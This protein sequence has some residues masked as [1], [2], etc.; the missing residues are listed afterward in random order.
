MSLT[1]PS[2]LT[3]PRGHDVVAEW[4]RR[5]I[6]RG[7]LASTF[8]FV[9]PEGIGKRTFA[10]WLAQSLLCRNSPD[11]AVQP[12]G[13]CPSCQQV[14]AGTHPDLELVAKPVDKSFIP[15]DLLIGDREHRMREG[16]CHNI[17]L[18]PFCG[19]RK[20]AIIDDA[21]FLN[22]EGANCLLKTLEEPPPNSLIILIGTSEQKQLP[23]IRSRCQIVRFNALSSELV[24]ELLLANGDTQSRDEA[25][26]WAAQ[27]EG[28][29]ARAVEVADQDLG[30]FREQLLGQLSVPGGNLL[31]FAREV[32]AFVDRAGK[33]AVARRNRLRRV[34]RIAAGFFHALMHALSGV[35]IDADVQLTS[36][37]QRR[38]ATWRGDAETAVACLERCFDAEA[39]ID[40]N[41]SLAIVV[42]C[43]LDDIGRLMRC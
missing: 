43:W 26:Q 21:D 42:E 11:D 32:N 10:L 19:G 17:A 39:H 8:L 20:L 15:I 37:L 12:C 35:A 18:K 25:E 4:F 33:D 23:T 7:R 2:S 27:A 6:A 40:A 24:A 36:S 28:S 16:L 14:A 5:A 22:Q 3:F 1:T 41:A 13:H 29:V 34:V 31:R 30:A 38:L 9:G